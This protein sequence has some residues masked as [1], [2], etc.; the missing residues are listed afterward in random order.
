MKTI[1]EQLME[2]KDV[3]SLHRSETTLFLGADCIVGDDVIDDILVNEKLIELFYKAYSIQEPLEQIFFERNIS[4]IGL[5]ISVAYNFQY[6]SVH[7]AVENNK[8]L[9]TFYHKDD[10]FKA[11]FGADRCMVSVD[12]NLNFIQ[13]EYSTYF[14]FLNSVLHNNGGYAGYNHMQ[15]KQFTDSAGTRNQLAF[16][17]PDDNDDL[18]KAAP[19]GKLDKRFSI[20]NVQFEN[21]FLQ[22]IDFVTDRPHEFYAIFPEY[23]SFSEC[24]DS[25]DGIINFVNLFVEQYFND[26]ER[27]QQHLLLLDMQAI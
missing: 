10:W 23:P 16:C 27:L 12:H 6:G 1:Y 9:V 2:L 19:E 5:R 14:A 7:L 24:V 8:L 13:S 15:I 22:I 26:N 11:P 4:S 21:T 3:K 18:F 25:A 17:H 20:P